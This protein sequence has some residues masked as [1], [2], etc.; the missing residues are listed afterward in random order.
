MLLASDQPICGNQ[1]VEEDEECDCGFEEDCLEV[2]DQCCTPAVAG[3]ENAG[4]K[5]KPESVCR[6]VF[7]LK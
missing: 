4:C 1:L 2:G 3:D 6:F 7:P 5:L